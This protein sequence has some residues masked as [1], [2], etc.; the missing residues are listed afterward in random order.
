VNDVIGFERSLLVNSA[1]DG[2]VY[3]VKRLKTMDKKWA[4]SLI[5]IT[6]DDCAHFTLTW[7]DLSCILG[8]ELVKK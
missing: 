1:N 8:V 4:S 2:G 7:F 3:S 5:I 6:H